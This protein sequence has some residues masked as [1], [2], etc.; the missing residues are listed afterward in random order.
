[1]VGCVWQPAVRWRNEIKSDQQRTC[2]RAFH[3]P[4]DSDRRERRE[5]KSECVGSTRNCACV[6]DAR[7]AGESNYD[8]MDWQNNHD[9]ETP[10]V[11]GYVRQIHFRGLGFRH[12]QHIHLVHR[13]VH[14]DANNMCVCVCVCIPAMSVP[15]SVCCM[16][17]LSTY[18]HERLYNIFSFASNMAVFGMRQRLWHIHGKMKNNN[19]MCDVCVCDGMWRC[20]AVDVSS[21][22]DTRSTAG[23]LRQWRRH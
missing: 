19:K 1:M 21:T 11:A 2:V 4:S 16:S 7:D 12:T 3:Y 17:L 10:L 9:E 6:I 5:S 8:L 13:T 20:I 22:H 15:Y 18:M 14:D 23:G